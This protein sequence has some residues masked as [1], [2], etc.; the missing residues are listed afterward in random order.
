MG[1]GWKNDK[2]YQSFAL[3]RK[4]RSKLLDDFDNED[5]DLLYFK[6]FTMAACNSKRIKIEVLLKKNLLPLINSQWLG[7][8]STIVLLV[9]KGY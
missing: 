6:S 9:L 7:M 2:T 4:K 1:F 3:N 5:L 8:K